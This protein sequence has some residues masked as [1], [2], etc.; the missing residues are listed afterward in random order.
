MLKNLTG[1]YQIKLLVQ[2]LSREI[3]Y[4]NIETGLGQFPGFRLEQINPEAGRGG[5]REMTM[6]PFRIF[7]SIKKMLHHSDVQDVLSSRQFTEI[8]DA[9]RNQ[10]GLSCSHDFRPA[11]L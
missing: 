11:Q 7:V 5:A 6:Q 1:D 2:G 8:S 9:V 4:H 3:R 10:A